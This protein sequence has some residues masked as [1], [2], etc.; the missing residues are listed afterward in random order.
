MLGTTI[1]AILFTPKA[2]RADGSSPFALPLLAALAIVH[3]ATEVSR[4]ESPLEARMRSGAEPSPSFRSRLPSQLKIPDAY[5]VN[6]YRNARRWAEPVDASKMVGF[7]LWPTPIRGFTPLVSY[8]KESRFIGRS[9]DV[10][11]FQLEMRW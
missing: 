7:D 5:H 9:N 2:A 8:D 11:R 3:Q 10:I 1:A 4:E 6:Y